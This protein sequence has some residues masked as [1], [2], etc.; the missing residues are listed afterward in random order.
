LLCKQFSK[1]KQ[2]QLKGRS[3]FKIKQIIIEDV[4]ITIK[5]QKKCDSKYGSSFW[6]NKEKIKIAKDDN[7]IH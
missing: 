7:T 6:K 1:R 3:H 2:K 4:K 5:E